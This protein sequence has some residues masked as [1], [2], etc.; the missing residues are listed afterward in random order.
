V[1]RTADLVIRNKRIAVFVDGC[2][3]HGCP[4]HFVLPRT[5]RKYWADKIAVNRRRDADTDEKLANEGW[6]VIRFWE[7]EPPGAAAAQ[8]VEAAK[9]PESPR[10]GERRAVF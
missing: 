4:K 7:H 2:Y 6:R 10:P 5:N 9:A 1:R 3:W 8:I